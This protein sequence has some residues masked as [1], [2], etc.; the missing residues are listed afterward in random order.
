M[1]AKVL[2]GAKPSSIPVRTNTSYKLVVSEENKTAIGLQ[3]SIVSGS[4][5]PVESLTEETT[6]TPAEVTEETT[7]AGTETTTIDQ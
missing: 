7:D 5:E 3:T 4:F 2:E 6:E 1:A